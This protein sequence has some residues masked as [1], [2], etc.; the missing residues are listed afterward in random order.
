MHTNLKYQFSYFLKLDSVVNVISATV[1]N[2]C[3]TVV[4][5]FAEKLESWRL[6][7]ES[8]TMSPVVCI[9]LSGCLHS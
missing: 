3:P 4:K 9:E 5:H 8:N 1:I 2:S 6:K 7:L